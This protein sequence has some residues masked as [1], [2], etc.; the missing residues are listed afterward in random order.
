MAAEGL[1]ALGR[2]PNLSLMR[3]ILVVCACFAAS[4]ALAQG[5]AIIPS[6]Y[7]SGVTG[8]EPLDPEPGRLGGPQS[9]MLDP[10][11]QA[12]GEY[13]QGDPSIARRR[14]F[15]RRIPSTYQRKYRVEHHGGAGYR[16]Y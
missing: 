15:Q 12:T 2:R 7:P 10:Y 11:P 16:A 13:S 5:Q 6:P 1:A 9:I 4:A 14:R 3:T 8:A